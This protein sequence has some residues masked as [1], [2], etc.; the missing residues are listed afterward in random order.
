MT[1]SEPIDH[2]ARP[3]NDAVLQDGRRPPRWMSSSEDAMLGI[4]LLSGAANVIMELAQPE[5]GHGVR[6][7]RVESG[8]VDRHPVKRARTTF[9]YVA[10]A[11][12][13][14]ETQ[15]AAYRNAVNKQHAQVYST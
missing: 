13:G 14:S 5:V 12:E 3:V 7:S 11:L 15:R 2:V 6:E 4:G 10:V 8:R 9:T 1:I